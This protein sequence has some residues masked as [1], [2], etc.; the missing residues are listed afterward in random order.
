MTARSQPIPIE[1][2]SNPAADVIA[3]PKGSKEKAVKDLPRI[4]KSIMRRSH[5]PG[6]AVAVV[7]DGKM[8]FAQ[9]YGTRRIGKNEPVDARTVFQIASVSKSVS[10][11]VAALEVTKGTVAWADPVLRYLPHFRFNNTNLANPATHGA[12]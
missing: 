2:G 8:V 4:V 6:M 3:I 10:A 9:G 5:V 1:S 12:L 11:T 7:M